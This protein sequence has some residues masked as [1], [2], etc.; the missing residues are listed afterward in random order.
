VN[1]FNN[2]RAFGEKCEQAISGYFVEN[3]WEFQKVPDS[4][5]EQYDFLATKDGVSRKVEIKSDK[6]AEFTGNVFV[7]TGNQFG[8]PAGL[9]TSEADSYFFY[10]PMSQTLYDIPKVRLLFLVHDEFAKRVSS[11]TRGVL[12][13]FYQMAARAREYSIFRDA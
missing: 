13:P 8:Q 2:D 10:L 1:S 9:L 11:P 12:L 5:R 4:I 6:R 3:G 7:E